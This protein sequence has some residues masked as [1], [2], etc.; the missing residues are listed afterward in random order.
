MV[1]RYYAN[2]VGLSLFLAAECL[3][4]YS[5]VPWITG[6]VSGRRVGG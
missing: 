4:I 6:V 1:Q 3:G 2:G 5:L